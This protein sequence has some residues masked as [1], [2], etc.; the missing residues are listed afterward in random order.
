MGGRIKPLG[1]FMVQ[2]FRKIELIHAVEMLLN[3]KINIKI[4]KQKIDLENKIKISAYTIQQHG[5]NKFQ[6][7]L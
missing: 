5:I 7:I 1:I 6:C 4:A 2:I 3:L